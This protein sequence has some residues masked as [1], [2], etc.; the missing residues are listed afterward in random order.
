[1][2]Y[3]YSWQKTTS[4]HS[5]TNFCVKY[6]F[7][8]Q[9]NNY[10]YFSVFKPLRIYERSIGNKRLSE[11]VLPIPGIHVAIISHWNHVKDDNRV[12]EV[13]MPFL[14][15]LIVAADVYQVK[16]VV[17]LRRQ[18]RDERKRNG[19]LHGLWG[20]TKT[21]VVWLTIFMCSSSFTSIRQIS[22]CR[23]LSLTV[24]VSRSIITS[25]NSGT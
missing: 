10:L 2:I 25:S 19:C 9:H 13:L 15:M 11:G 20:T 23:P 3:T 8:G 24:R 14:S 1:M 21:I 16:S 7:F 12:M 17:L 4:I 18:K 6:I 22:A 5:P